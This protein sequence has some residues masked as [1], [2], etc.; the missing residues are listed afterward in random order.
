M[1]EP[2]RLFTAGSAKCKRN[3]L[4]TQQKYELIRTLLY[5]AVSV[6]LFAAGYLQT[7]S[8]NN[9][10]TLVAVLGCLPASKSA[11]SMIMYFRFHGCSKEA[12]DTIEKHSEGLHCLYDCYFTS[13]SKNYKISHITV[14]GNTVCGFSEDKDFSENEFYKHISDLLKL[15]GHKDISI[16]IFLSL[17]KYTERMEQM[18]ALD[19][20]EE[21]TLSVM[22]TLMSVAL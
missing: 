13:Y 14:S 8:R 19:S 5:F 20:D 22:N 4:K 10:L 17:D 7:G 21:K 2:K 3:Y 1:F 12:A 18:K 15:D 16:K 9:L 6:T 11:I